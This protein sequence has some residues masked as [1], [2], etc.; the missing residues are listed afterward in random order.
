MKGLFKTCGRLVATGV[1]VMNR[2][3]LHLCRGVDKSLRR[4]SYT[5]LLLVSNKDLNE[6]KGVQSALV[7]HVKNSMVWENTKNIHEIRKMVTELKECLDGQGDVIQTELTNSSRHING[8]VNF[9]K[10]RRRPQRRQ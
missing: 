1:Y 2:G 9:I 4:Y 5:K 6:L 3:A 7:D 8:L 10:G